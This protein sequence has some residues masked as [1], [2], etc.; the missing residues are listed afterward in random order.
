M[1]EDMQRQLFSVGLLQE[2][3]K[4]SNSSRVCLAA[5]VDIFISF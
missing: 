5:F 2:R 4:T 1:L 3:R